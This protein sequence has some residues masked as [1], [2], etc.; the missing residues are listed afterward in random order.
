[1]VSEERII[2]KMHELERELGLSFKEIQW[3]AIAMNST[4]L[5]KLSGDGKNKKPDCNNTALATVGDAILKAILSDFLFLCFTSENKMAR[6]G[7]IT[8]AKERLENNQVLYEVMGRYD[9][10]KYTY[11]DYAFYTDPQK[12][13]ERTCR[14][15]ESLRRGRKPKGQHSCACNAHPRENALQCGRDLY[16]RSLLPVGRG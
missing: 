9:L 11:N 13:H 16:F 7:E 3:L 10:K 8:H 14:R 5:P 15:G 12:D 1:M 6:K 4:R 2:E